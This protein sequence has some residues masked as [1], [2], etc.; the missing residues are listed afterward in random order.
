VQ[1]TFHCAEICRR[2]RAEASTSTSG[3]TA[4]ESRRTGSRQLYLK[5]SRPPIHFEGR[6]ASTEYARSHDEWIQTVTPSL[7]L[8]INP[9]RGNSRVSVRMPAHLKEDDQLINWIRDCV[10][11]DADGKIIEGGVAAAFKLASEY[12]REHYEA[13]DADARSRTRLKHLCPDLSPVFLPLDLSQ[14]LSD[15]DQAHG[16]TRRAYV[17]PS[18]REIRQVLNLAVVKAAAASGVQM[19]T[20]D[21]DGTVYSD[22]SVLESTSPMIPILIRLMRLG[23]Q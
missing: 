21:L 9:L 20:L 2:N 1:R 4:I 18:H 5:Y 7:P 22:G 13:L 11:K 8:S 23:I 10:S 3:V 6:G 16:L 12:L 19:V 15:Y 17:A 14:A